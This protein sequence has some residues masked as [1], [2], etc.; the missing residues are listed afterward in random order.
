[1]S[2]KIAWLPG[3]LM[4]TAAC[5]DDGSPEDNHHDY[6]DNH[7]IN[8]ER[9]LKSLED[10]SAHE[11]DE[12]LTAAAPWKVGDIVA[13]WND[14]EGDYDYRRFQGI[15]KAGYY[16]VQDY[17]SYNYWQEHAA[18]SYQPEPERQ[19]TAPFALM[20][21]LAVTKT[22]SSG[23]PT[24]SLPSAC[25]PFISTSGWGERCFYLDGAVEG[26]RARGL[27]SISTYKDGVPHGLGIGYASNGRRIS[28]FTHDLNGL[29]IVAISFY[30]NGRIRVASLP[31][32]DG[33][34]YF[35]GF[36][37]RGQLVTQGFFAAPEKWESGASG[38]RK[39]G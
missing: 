26:V 2:G 20:S 37:E 13:K 16:L 34:T 6:S 14:G 31:H 27:V 17:E 1:M 39:A 8:R 19:M 22:K 23:R 32:K 12:S 5:A 28:S 25:G 29:P 4:L 15:T 7:A 9:C 30:E 10:G 35:T 24:P 18:D 11:I 33:I 36:D 3:L 21:R 38:I